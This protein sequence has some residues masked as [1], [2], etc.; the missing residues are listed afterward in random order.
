[1]FYAL[2]GLMV[3]LLKFNS[4]MVRMVLILWEV[5]AILGNGYTIQG[6][7]YPALL[8]GGEMSIGVHTRNLMSGI[9]F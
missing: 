4:H 8:Q 2:F 7:N 1:M 3:I 5:G 6:N 9:M